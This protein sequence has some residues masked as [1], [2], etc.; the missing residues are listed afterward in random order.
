[1]FGI[2]ETY[3]RK[4]PFIQGKM[5]DRGSIQAARRRVDTT[6]EG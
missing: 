2:E 4:P 1:M 6:G 5:D 3:R